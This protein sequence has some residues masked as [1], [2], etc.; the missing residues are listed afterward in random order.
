MKASFSD[1]YGKHYVEGVEEDRS[2]EV[3]ELF[4]SVYADQI[5]NACAA[6]GLDSD[7]AE[8][9]V[10]F[11]LSEDTSTEAAVELVDA[12]W[13]RAEIKKLEKLGKGFASNAEISPVF[14]WY[15]VALCA[16]VMAVLLVRLDDVQELIV[17]GAGVEKVKGCVDRILKAM[18]A[19][20]E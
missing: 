1:I 10:D 14:D 20:L 16:G 8:K 19:A 4:R 3:Y 7:F 6:G 15:D 13:A 5:K 18:L 2:E 12:L 9:V 17:E 11:T